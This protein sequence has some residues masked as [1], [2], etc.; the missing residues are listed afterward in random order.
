[1]PILASGVSER[2]IIGEGFARP[3]GPQPGAHR[4][5]AEVKC[6]VRGLRAPFHQLGGSDECCKLPAVGCRAQPQPP[7]GFP[8]F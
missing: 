7:N 2:G 8:I 1:M 3:E 6:T 5:E 4:A